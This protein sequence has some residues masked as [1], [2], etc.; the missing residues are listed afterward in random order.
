MEELYKEY[1]EKLNSKIIQEIKNNVPEKITKAQL[2]K[3]L[4]TTVEVY[5]DSKVHAGECIGLI[6]AQSIGEPGTQMV[7]NTF[8]LAGVAEMNV[9]MGLPRVIEILD[10]TKSISTPMMEV[11]L[12]EPYCKGEDIKKIAMQIKE[13]KVEDVAKEFSINIADFTITITFDEDKIKL[14]DLTMSKVSKSLAKL[15]K[16]S[17]AKAD[18]N[19]I[20]MKLNSKGESVNT[21]YKFKEK[22]KQTS[23]SGV[24]GIKQILPVK[25]G[26]EYIILTAGSNMKTILALEY[27]DAYR[28][29]TNDINEISN[30]LGIE[31]ARQ[32]IINE[33]M[34][35]ID[36][37]GLKVDIRHI[38]LVADTM[39]VSGN[40]KGI[41]RYGVVSEKSSVLARASFETPLKH[42][43]RASIVGEEDKLTSVIENVMLNQPV[44]I[45]TGL[46]SLRTKIGKK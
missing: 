15:S 41:T 9:T 44:P 22:I 33:V 25:R 10:A 5:E 45:G 36:S 27:V 20:V 35:V 11:Y 32:S 12:K 40:V 21:L 8:H 2:K 14:L 19:N 23:I 18:G 28:T 30:V 34:K 6:A 4:D 1:A 37:Q 16:T 17:D 43:I 29:T 26:E 13:I 46:P 24:K 39:C 7:L 31:A 38:M 42:I 3:I